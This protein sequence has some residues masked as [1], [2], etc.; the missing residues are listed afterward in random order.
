MGG[1]GLN[2]TAKFVILTMK[3]P[4]ILCRCEAV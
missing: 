1:T 3:Y 2:E 4:H